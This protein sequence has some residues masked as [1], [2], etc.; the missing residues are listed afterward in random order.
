MDPK[1]LQK[2]DNKLEKIKNSDNV[3]TVLNILDKMIAGKRFEEFD[4]AKQMYLMDCQCK[5][6]DMKNGEFDESSLE[7]L[8]HSVNKLMLTLIVAKDEIE[9]AYKEVKNNE[10]I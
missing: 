6:Q 8:H 4:S 5:L 10:S 1:Y 3:K 9:N 7:F 2:Q